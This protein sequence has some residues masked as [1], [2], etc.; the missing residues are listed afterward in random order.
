MLDTPVAWEELSGVSGLE[1]C[2]PLRNNQG[3]LFALTEEEFDIIRVVI[4][5]KNATVSPHVVEAY[6]KA[7][8]LS[9]LFIDAEDLDEMIRRLRRK[10][11]LILRRSS[12]SWEDLHC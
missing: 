4:D 5:E 12:R 11:N 6:S 2:E 7:D 8:A 3:S 1:Q 10:K 9:E